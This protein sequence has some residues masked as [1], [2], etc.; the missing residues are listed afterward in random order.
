M[1][2]D[3]LYAYTNYSLP[4]SLAPPD[5]FLLPF[6][7]NSPLKSS[8]SDIALLIVKELS[9]DGRTLQVSVCINNT[10]FLSDIQMYS[11]TE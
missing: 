8:Q 2:L 11:G 3:M 5:Y 10:S 1:Y 6:Y 7:K 9:K 4:V